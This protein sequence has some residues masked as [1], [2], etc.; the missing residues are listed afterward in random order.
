MIVHPRNKKEDKKTD[1]V[2]IMKAKL[3]CAWCKQVIGECETFDG[4]DS[5]GICPSCYDKVVKEIEDAKKPKEAEK[6][7]NTK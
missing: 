7:G 4:L 6:H 2:D 1:E 3:I 5:H